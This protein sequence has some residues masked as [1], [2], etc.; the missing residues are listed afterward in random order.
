VGDGEVA[1]PG[2]TRARTHYSL[3]EQGLDALC[4]WAAQ[5][6][7]FPRVLHEGVV[8]L[9]AADLVGEEP[10]RESI[11]ALR[12]ELVELEGSWTRRTRPRRRCP[13]VRSTS[14]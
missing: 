10:V 7:R 5:P 11:S 3:T 12:E 13:T 4:E 6:V 2:Q 8:R 1:E 9:L 14:A